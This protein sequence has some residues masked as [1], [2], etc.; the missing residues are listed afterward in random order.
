MHLPQHKPNVYALQKLMPK[1]DHWCVPSDFR[2]LIQF[3][4]ENEEEKKCSIN[5]MKRKKFDRKFYE[6]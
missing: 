1:P 3:P 5:Q 4:K 2:H 6:F